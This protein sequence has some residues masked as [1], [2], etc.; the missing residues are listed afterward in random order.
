MNWEIF[1]LGNISGIALSIIG[2]IGLKL[3]SGG[4]D[5]DGGGR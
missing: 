2:Y 5:D 1:L 4:H 3:V